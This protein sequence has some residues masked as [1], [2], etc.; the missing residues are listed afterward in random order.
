M[1]VLRAAEVAVLLTVV[2]LEQGMAV[3]S[4][5]ATVRLILALGTLST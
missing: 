2:G 5:M 1:L 3:A 4:A